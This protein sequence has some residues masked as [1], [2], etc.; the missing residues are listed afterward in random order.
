MAKRTR[1]PK[2]SYVRLMDV[3]RKTG[4]E[5]PGSL[6]RVLLESLVFDDGK[7]TSEVFYHQKAGSKG[8]FTKV[9]DSLV[10]DG[11]ILVL[12]PSGKILAKTRLKLYADEAMKQTQA[13]VGFVVDYVSSKVKVVENEVLDLKSQIA[14]IRELITQIKKLQAPPPTMAAQELTAKLTGRLESLLEQQSAVRQ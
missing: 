12:E 4:Y 3:L 5:N 2:D 10:K 7:L 11:F 9:R 1:L 6:A 8:T 14:E 13:S